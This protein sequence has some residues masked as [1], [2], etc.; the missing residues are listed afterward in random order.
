METVRHAT[1]ILEIEL[2]YF[3]KKVSFCTPGTKY[4]T[5]K[6]TSQSISDETEQFL[7]DCH[8]VLLAVQDTCT[9]SQYH[10]SV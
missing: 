1:I 7:I 6:A 5:E 2:V 10:A 9:L 3:Q 8:D 4:E